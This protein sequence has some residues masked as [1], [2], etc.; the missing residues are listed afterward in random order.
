[1][2]VAPA[3]IGD[4]AV[5]ST[6]SARSPHTRQN[7]LANARSPHVRRAPSRCAPSRRRDSGSPPAARARAPR[8]S[9]AA[10]SAWNAQ[11]R[12]A[13][14]V[15]VPSGNTAT[16]SPSASA[17]AV[18]RVHAS[19]VAPSLA[20]DED[21]AGAADQATDEHGQRASSDLA[22]KRAGC[23][24]L[25]TKMSSH[26]TWLATMRTLP[27][28]TVDR[29]VTRARRRSACAAAAR[30]QRRISLRL[31]GTLTNGNTHDRRRKPGRDV[32]RD[33]RCAPARWTTT[34]AASSPELRRR[35]CLSYSATRRSSRSTSVV[36]RR[37]ATRS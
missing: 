18:W 36:L 21:R 4:G 9:A 2:L 27:P 3:A 30:L 32:Q 26:E 15:V 37:R 7:E 8:R 23:C 20:L 1:M 33:A 29:A 19:R 10:A 25:S 34:V 22:T 17:S 6:T 12:R 35:T 16:T 14:R 31:R 28:S 13:R 24:A 5:R 11:Q